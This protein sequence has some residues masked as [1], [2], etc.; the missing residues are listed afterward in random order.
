MFSKNP[1]KESL[2]QFLQAKCDTAI[3]V[4]NSV[5]QVYAA[6]PAPQ[7]SPYRRRKPKPDSYQQEIERLAL[8]RD[9]PPA[10]KTAADKCLLADGTDLDIQTL[11]QEANTFVRNRRR[12]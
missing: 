3:L 12:K 2:R 8:A 4:D 1:S 9:T 7:R 6:E 10:A 5:H 11:Q